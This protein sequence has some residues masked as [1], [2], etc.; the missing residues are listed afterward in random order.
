MTSAVF[1]ALYAAAAGVLAP[2]RLSGRW[3]TRSPRLAICLWL[4]LPVS[5]VAAVATAILAAAAPS[6]LP[7]PGREQAAAR[8]CWPARHFLAGMRLPPQGCCWPPQWRRERL[9]A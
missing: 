3:A 6:R 2:A 4:V 9:D 5:W 8:G 1:F 7:G